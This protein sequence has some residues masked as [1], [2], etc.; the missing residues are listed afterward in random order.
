MLLHSGPPLLQRSLRT[1]GLLLA[2]HE[3]L[4]CVKVAFFLSRK[5]FLLLPP[6]SGLSHVVGFFLSSLQFFLRGNCS[7]SSCKFAVQMVGDEFSVHLCYHPD[8]SPSHG[9]NSV[10]HFSSQNVGSLI[11]ERNNPRRHCYH[12]L[13]SKSISMSSLSFILVPQ[14]Q[15]LE[16][17][18][19][20]SVLGV[21]GIHLNSI[22]GSFIQWDSM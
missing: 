8:T 20:P 3:G 1:L 6:Q 15:L 2:S 10:L 16:V 17:K 7:Q 21:S 18:I 13:I 5:E 14:K 11:F 19:R 4:Q 9:C 22:F 12:S